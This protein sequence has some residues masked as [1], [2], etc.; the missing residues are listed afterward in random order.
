MAVFFAALGLLARVACAFGELTD[1]VLYV[2]VENVEGRFSKTAKT[3]VKHCVVSK[4]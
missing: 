3:P 1:A 2:Y 4:V